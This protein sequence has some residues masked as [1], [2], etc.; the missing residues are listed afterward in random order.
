MLR[1]YSSQKKVGTILKLLASILDRCKGLL[2]ARR[3]RCTRQSPHCR[4][5]RQH[6]VM[7]ACDA[8]SF[9]KVLSVDL[10]RDE[11]FQEVAVVM[12]KALTPIGM[13]VDRALCTT[14]LG[15]AE[16]QH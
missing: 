16:E 8:K 1:L 6:D 15:Y 4:R 5:S 10:G 2:A 14:Y 9:D 13:N 7:G 12:L 11:R 3:M